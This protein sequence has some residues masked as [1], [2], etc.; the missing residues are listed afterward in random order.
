MFAIVAPALNTIS[1]SINTRMNL[2]RLQVAA[3]RAEDQ[4]G[5]NQTKP[6]AP[7]CWNLPGVG[8]CKPRAT[9]GDDIKQG[10]RQEVGSREMLQE[11]VP[12]P[13]GQLAAIPVEQQGQVGKAR[14]LPA[15]GLVEK[16]ML[17]GGD[18]PLGPTQYVA[19]AHVVVVHH[20]GQMIRGEAIAFQD[21]WVP[22]HMRHLMPIPAVH[23]VLEGWRFPFQAEADRRFG[24]L[25]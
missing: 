22:L 17:G 4:A 21:D 2:G 18:Q 7:R 16:Q 13:L 8:T 19:D 24:A 3:A 23:Q 9:V 11:N 5:L 12:L 15:Q 20:A 10:I 25:G 6:P 14:R 1:G